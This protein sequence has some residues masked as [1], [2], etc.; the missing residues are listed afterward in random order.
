MLTVPID[1][2]RDHTRGGP[3]GSVT[4]VEYGDYECPYSR[5]AYRSVE[6]IEGRLGDRM[7]FVFRHFPLRDIHP[8]AQMAAEAAEAAAEQGRFWEMHDLLFH[9]QRALEPADLRRY[10]GEL[11]LDLDEFDAALAGGRGRARIEE[12]IASG[13]RSGVLGTPTLFI[14]GVLYEGSYAPDE[15]E[16]ALIAA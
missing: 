3:A 5:A 1:S 9:R 14:D 6:R 11:G 2:E 4:L 15:L 10:A 12:D 13:E 16:H 8:H 7:R